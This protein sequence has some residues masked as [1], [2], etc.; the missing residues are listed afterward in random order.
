MA[1]IALGVVGLAGIYGAILQALEHV[2]AAISA[3][4]DLCLLDTHLNTA[5]AS[6]S[7]WGERVGLCSDGSLDHE[8]HPIFDDE[9]RLREVQRAMAAIKQVAGQLQRNLDK[10]KSLTAT[11]GHAKTGALEALR[12]KARLGGSAAK[13]FRWAAWD[14]K[15]FE[16]SLEQMLS[17]ISLLYDIVPVQDLALLGMSA[18]LLK[19]L[20]TTKGML[21][22]AYMRPACH[23]FSNQ[24]TTNEHCR[25]FDYSCPNRHNTFR[26]S[27]EAFYANASSKAAPDTCQ[28]ILQDED[29]KRWLDPQP[30]AQGPPPPNPP[31]IW[32]Y[33]KHAGVGKTVAVAKLIST[34]KATDKTV[35]YFFCTHETSSLHVVD[36]IVKTWIHQLSR[37]AGWDH[38][39]AAM[40]SAEKGEPVDLWATLRALVTQLPPVYLIIDGIDE[41]QDQQVKYQG[42]VRTSFLKRLR[43]ELS[44]SAARVLIMSRY[45]PDIEEALSTT[46]DIKVVARQQVTS[47]LTSLSPEVQDKLVTEVVEKADGLFILLVSLLDPLEDGMSE[48]RVRTMLSESIGG[49]KAATILDQAYGIWLNRILTL[50]DSDTRLMCLSILF[51]LLFSCRPLEVGEM[52]DAL[53]FD[54][55]EPSQR[56]RAPEIL[57]ESDFRAKLLRHFGGYSCFR[58]PQRA[59][60]YVQ[61]IASLSSDRDIPKWLQYRDHRS[62]NTHITKSCLHYMMQS[63]LDKYPALQVP[64]SVFHKGYE[65]DAGFY[66]RLRAKAPFYDYCAEFWTRHMDL[67]CPRPGVAMCFDISPEMLEGKAGTSSAKALLTVMNAVTFDY[68]R[69]ADRVFGYDNPSVPS[70]LFNWYFWRDHLFGAYGYNR[71]AL[72]LQSRLSHALRLRS[73][74]LAALIVDHGADINFLMPNRLTTYQQWTARVGRDS[75]L[76]MYVLRNHFGGNFKLKQPDQAIH[77]VFGNVSFQSPGTAWINPLRAKALLLG[78][79]LQETV[80]YWRVETEHGGQLLRA[81]ISHGQDVNNKSLLG[82]SAIHSAAVLGHTAALRI[83]ISNDADANIG[84]WLRPTST[85]IGQAWEVCQTVFEM[86][87][88]LLPSG[89]LSHGRVFGHLLEVIEQASGW[90]GTH[91]ESVLKLLLSEDAL[92][93]NSA[94]WISRE[95]IHMA[96]RI[97]LV[98]KVQALLKEGANPNLSGPWYGT[99]LFVACYTGNMD[100]VRLLLEHADINLPAKSRI[101]RLELDASFTWSGLWRKSLRNPASAYTPLQAAAYRGHY[102]VV[103]LLLDSGAEINA[104]AGNA[105]TALYFAVLGA[106][107]KHEG[108]LREAERQGGG[109]VDYWVKKRKALHETHLKIVTLLLERG[110][111]PNS[112]GGRYW[113]PCRWRAWPGTWTWSP[114]CSGPRPTPTPPAG[115]RHPL[116]AL[117]ANFPENNE[118]ARYEGMQM[119]PGFGLVLTGW[120]NRF[121]AA[122]YAILYIIMSLWA[123]PDQTFKILGL[124]LRAG[125]DPTLISGKGGSA[126]HAAAYSSSIGVLALLLQDDYSTLEARRKTVNYDA[127]LLGTALDCATGTFRWDKALILRLWADSEIRFRGLLRLRAKRIFVKSE[128]TENNFVEV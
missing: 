74:S 64:S 99:P 35:G 63:E 88:E 118:E 123:P 60:E 51:W 93:A 34:L 96:T 116:Q 105:G 44:S 78:N 69:Q 20:N 127:P 126:L 13:R 32:L 14:K 82:P 109:Q 41:V 43:Q 15:N 46:A 2:G 56:W 17:L 49:P 81:M 28:W 128:W 112:T 65:Y 90:E 100:M 72:R 107:F 30:E 10:Y 111:S 124:L 95:R 39:E 114:L 22:D 97:D 21:H 40:E 115:I 79:N 120:S 108:D 12:D 73:A 4:S 9:V 45:E 38:V 50:S 80:T 68:A 33:S 62:A 92:A 19:L 102:D 98:D 61:G 37:V 57:H 87:Q 103:K 11:P 76:F 119:E 42:G 121:A 26:R 110:A 23:S 36:G 58:M 71:R 6:L 3:S 66:D 47:R 84:A 94:G 75:F 101:L 104:N 16:S 83:L 53:K 1:D 54:L 89:Q 70:R 91:R 67:A 7:S 85:L 122:P 27:C 55:D 52:L 25:E 18:N 31:H 125:A 8:H 117:L 86:L 29:V 113:C 106:R 5:R 59:A 77:F 48:S 24:L